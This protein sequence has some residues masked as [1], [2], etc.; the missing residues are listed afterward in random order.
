MML[1][2][3][4]PASVYFLSPILILSAGATIIGFVIAL[5]LSLR[6][7]TRRTAQ[8]LLRVAI[9]SV[10]FEIALL[11]LLLWLDAR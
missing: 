5:L 1:A 3:V 9:Y 4:P 2:D 8:Q 10:P 7:Q 11:L 6:M